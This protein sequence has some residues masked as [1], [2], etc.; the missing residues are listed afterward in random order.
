[1]GKNVT[2]NHRTFTSNAQKILKTQKWETDSYTN[3]NVFF[4]LPKDSKRFEGFG[5][6]TLSVRVN[7]KVI[8]RD[9]TDPYMNKPSTRSYMVSV[10]DLEGVKIKRARVIGSKPLKRLK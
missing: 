3:G 1:M 5:P 2:L 4:F 9:N 7:H 6:S 8:K 10:K